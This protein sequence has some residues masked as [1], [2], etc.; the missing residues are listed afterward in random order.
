MRKL[1]V[2]L[3]VMFVVGACTAKN[4]NENL[5]GGGSVNDTTVVDTTVVMS[6]AADSTA[7][8]VP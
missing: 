8:L 4:G 3:G 1:L 6:V 7:A 2:I 5:P